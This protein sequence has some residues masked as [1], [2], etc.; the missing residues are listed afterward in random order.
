MIVLGI[1]TSCDETS[2]AV[3]RDGREVLS[4]EVHSQIA[5]HEAWGGVVPEIAAR[6]HAERLPGLLHRAVENAG[7]AWQELDAVAVTRGPG[8]AT[9]LLV[10]FSAARALAFRLA[11]PLYLLNHLE[12]HLYSLFLDPAAPPPDEACPLLVLTVSG[13][14]TCLVTLRADGR[15]RL[16][17]QT[18]DDAAGEALDKAAVLLDLGYPGGPAIERAAR[19]GNPKAVEFPRGRVTSSPAGLENLDAD[20]CFSFSG[21][22]TSLR[23]HLRD[24]PVAPGDDQRR[25][26]LAA[27]FQVAVMDA[28]VSRVERALQ[29]GSHRGV[30]CVGGVARNGL[31][32]ERMGRAAARAGVPLHL[33]PPDFCTDNAAMVAGLAGARPWPD[34]RGNPAADIA[35]S[36]HL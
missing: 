28:L 34:E 11:R 9:S 24:E 35:P 4:S 7:V 6:S 18:I 15:H 26:D 33:A 12:G 13:G 8:L 19:G 16:L 30:A 36:L 21:L 14:H 31:L 25:R 10:G 22:K 2:V 32:R 20:L 23:Y 5:Q 27:S 17:G 29:N 3:V 1:E